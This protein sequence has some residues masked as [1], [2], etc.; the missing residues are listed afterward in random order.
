MGRRRPF[1]QPC[2]RDDDVAVKELWAGSRTSGGPPPTLD[3]C[4]QWKANAQTIITERD[5]ALTRTTPL[6]PR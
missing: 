4:L 1:C 6:E 3:H 2:R 5:Q